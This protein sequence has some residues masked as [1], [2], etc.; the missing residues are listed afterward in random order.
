[1]EVDIVSLE[2]EREEERDKVGGKWERERE[3]QEEGEG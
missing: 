1:M 2:W 3:G